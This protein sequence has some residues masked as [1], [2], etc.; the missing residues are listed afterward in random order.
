ME[1]PSTYDEYSVY[2]PHS[3]VTDPDRT[4]DDD[5]P[6]LDEVLLAGYAALG[7]QME[8]SWIETDFRETHG[9]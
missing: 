8:A 6:T 7:Y 9:V 5:K 2:V 3:Q 1:M 4:W